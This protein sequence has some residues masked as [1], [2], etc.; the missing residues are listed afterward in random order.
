MSNCFYCGG[1]WHQATG[2]Y[3]PSRGLRRCGPCAKRQVARAVK[4]GAYGTPDE[5]TQKVMADALHDHDG[6]DRCLQCGWEAPR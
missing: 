5:L 6:L 2:D 4:A 3:D 1:A